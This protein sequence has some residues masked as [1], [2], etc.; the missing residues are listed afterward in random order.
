MDGK[1]KEQ[2][3]IGIDAM[4]GDFAPVNEVIGAK[5]ACLSDSSSIKIYFFGKKDQ[6]EEAVAK[7]DLQN[8][9]HEI[10][11]A[12]EI[13]TMD[14]D[15]TYVIKKKKNSSMYKG[16]E[17][18]R[19]RQIDAFVSAGNTGAMLSA[20]T[21]VLGRIKGVSRPTIGT[22]FPGQSGKSILLVDAGASIDAKARYL[23]EFGVM[24][25]IYSNV[26]GVSNPKVGLLNIGE[27]P[28]KGTEVVK[29]TYKMLSQ[30]DM[31]FIGNIEGQEVL[32][33]KADVVVCDGFTG[34]ILLKFA[35]SF[36]GLLKSKMKDHA[37][38]SLLNALNVVLAKGTLKKVL[39]DFDY[40]EYG[41]VP[42]LG[43]NGVSFIGHGKST[44]KAIKNMI[45]NAAEVVRS[46]LTG[47]I[48]KALDK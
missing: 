45:L 37:D 44:P 41:G 27:E 7:N 13:V 17:M 33:G 29:E 6:V 42:L 12:E 32:A 3:K 22:F 43:V 2:I 40:Q 4:G 9:E 10:I 11:H 31:N 24:G 19:D 30:A 46:D 35:E 20:S 14:D 38:K 25:N 34:N 21:V 18:L 23:Y 39:K 16:L 8:V 26:F 36:L 28:A 48:L 15:P 1:S 47:K 5:E